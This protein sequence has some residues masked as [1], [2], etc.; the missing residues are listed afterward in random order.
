MP[1]RTQKGKPVQINIGEM[2]K[3]RYK[4]VQQFVD[5][6]HGISCSQHGTESIE[7]TKVP[8]K[9]VQQHKYIKNGK[10]KN[11]IKK[12]AYLTHESL[13]PSSDLVSQAFWDWIVEIAMIEGMT[14]P[15]ALSRHPSST[16]KAK[17]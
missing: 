6:L 8:Y 3:V 11:E 14:A 16:E 1:A 5:I 9:P 12:I 2:S 7:Q 10:S 17:T 4:W 15:D 13:L